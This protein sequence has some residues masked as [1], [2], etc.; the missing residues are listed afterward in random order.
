MKTFSIL[1]TTIQLLQLYCFILSVSVPGCNSKLDEKQSSKTLNAIINGNKALP[2]PFFVTVHIVGPAN[3][4]CGG[5]LIADQWVL[6][7]GSCLN[8]TTGMTRN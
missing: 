7:S 5:T 8:S 4:F 3:L 6:T 1:A 2:H